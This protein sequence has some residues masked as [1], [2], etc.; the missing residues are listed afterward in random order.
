MKIVINNK[1]GGFGLSKAG[2][3][4][5]AEIKGITLYPEPKLSFIM[6]YTV[7]EDERIA[8]AGDS[9][10]KMTLD[11]RQEYNK[12]YRSQILNEHG[13]ERNDPALIQVF[14]ELGEKANGVHADL[15]VVDI[16]DDVNW[17]IEEYDGLEWVAEVRR[18]WN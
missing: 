2:V 3:M 18:T 6:Y 4:R 10:Y 8:V 5:Y 7:P 14:E 13:I 9:F 1:H 12:K 15:K 16:P 11:E 17:E